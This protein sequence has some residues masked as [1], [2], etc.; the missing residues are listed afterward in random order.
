[1]NL[2]EY[3]RV[4]LTILHGQAPIHKNIAESSGWGIAIIYALKEGYR[5]VYKRKNRLIK[6]TRWNTIWSRDRLPKTNVFFWILALRKT[7]TTENLRKR[8]IV[9]RFV[10]SCVNMRKA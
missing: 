2:R 5:M 7:L 4:L 6:K 9:G 1:M 8:G 3:Y 10:A